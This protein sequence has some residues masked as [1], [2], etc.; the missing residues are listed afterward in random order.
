VILVRAIID[1]QFVPAA[2]P[3]N[4]SSSDEIVESD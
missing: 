1:R 4:A 2:A 3:A